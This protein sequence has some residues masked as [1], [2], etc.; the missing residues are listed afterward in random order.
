MK[1]Q[2]IP[3]RTIAVLLV[4]LIVLGI[5]MVALGKVNPVGTVEGMMKTAEME[6][7]EDEQK[8]WEQGI[9]PGNRLSEEVNLKEPYT[10]NI[11]NKQTSICYGNAYICDIPGA[12]DEESGFCIITGLN[13]SQW[14]K[15]VDDSNRG[16]FS[17]TFYDSKAEKIAE[18]EK[19]CIKHS[20]ERNNKRKYEAE[21]DYLKIK[22]NPNDVVSYNVRFTILKGSNRIFGWAWTNCR[23]CDN[24][25]NSKPY[26]CCDDGCM[27]ELS[28]YYILE[29]ESNIRGKYCCPDPRETGEDWHWDAEKQACCIGESCS[30]LECENNGG[31][32]FAGR[33]W[34]IDGIKSCTAV[35]SAKGM[36]CQEPDWTKV[37]ENCK[38]HE[39]LGLTCNICNESSILF[40]TVSPIITLSK[41]CYYHNSTETNNLFNCDAMLPGRRL[42]PCVA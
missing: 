26:H 13:V 11:N 4:V 9:C 41:N 34:L 31:I 30:N 12:K 24:C 33:C 27:C 5:S 20:K 39:E 7:L 6:K 16:L 32:Y 18:E 28:P 21:L 29:F 19:S 17:F 3:I 22:V 25:G 38:L 42:C 1:G 8:G 23:P 15:D 40:N 36:T 14:V 35:C 10:H 37:P 2:S